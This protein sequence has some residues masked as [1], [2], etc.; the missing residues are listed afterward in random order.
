MDSANLTHTQE[1]QPDIVAVLEE[2]LA[3]I[4]RIPPDP[5]SRYQEPVDDQSESAGWLYSSSNEHT[6]GKLEHHI[7]PEPGT[8]AF[9]VGP[10]QGYQLLGMYPGLS[11]L[12]VVDNSD[13]AVATASAFFR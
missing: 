8:A 7:Q 11:G 4:D 2:Q 1:D 9:A 13:A 6:F 3:V 5:E 10:T 12:R